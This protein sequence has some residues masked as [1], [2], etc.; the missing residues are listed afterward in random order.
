MEGPKQAHLNSISDLPTMEGPK[1]PPRKVFTQDTPT[2][3]NNEPKT[4]PK[5]PRM[6]RTAPVNTRARPDNDD[7]DDEAI[8]SKERPGES[9]TLKKNR[10]L[11]EATHTDPRYLDRPIARPVGP[12]AAPDAPQRPKRHRHSD[13]AG[14]A[15][16]QEGGLGMLGESPP[17]AGPRPFAEGDGSRG[18]QLDDP[19]GT[20][21][22]S[23]RF[24]VSSSTR[25]GTGEEDGSDSSTPKASRVNKRRALSKDGDGEDV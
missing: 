24:S 21:R 6:V 22:V 12:R 14:G 3:D 5:A 20:P 2:P 11:L 10:Q 13:P 19:F 8:F 4:P 25:S 18:L 23:R 9:P 1:T 15:V 17:L 7:D 16:E